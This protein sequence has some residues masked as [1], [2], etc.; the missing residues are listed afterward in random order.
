MKVS[1]VLIGA[2]VGAGIEI[3]NTIY[4]TLVPFPIRLILMTVAGATMG[5]GAS[6]AEEDKS[7]FQERLRSAPS[8]KA[9]PCHVCG[10]PLDNG[11]KLCPDCL[12]VTPA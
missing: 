12:E 7:G 9:K 4:R 2:A 8:K 10:R 5:Y 6:V 3:A 11:A 1:Y